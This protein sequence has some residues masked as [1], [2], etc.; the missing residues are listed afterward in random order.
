MWISQCS[1][2]VAVPFMCSYRGD[3]SQTNYAVL[4]ED[5]LLFDLGVH[6][7]SRVR[8]CLA[9]IQPFDNH[10]SHTNNL[11]VG[12]GSKLEECFTALPY[13]HSACCSNRKSDQPCR[14]KVHTACYWPAFRTHT[15]IVDPLTSMSS[16]SSHLQ[17]LVVNLDMLFAAWPQPLLALLAVMAC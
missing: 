1:F 3:C 6:A 15:C 14:Q 5:V 10:L 16:S 17:D 9:V 2:V 11:F 12:K 13:G 7:S 8:T 4:Q